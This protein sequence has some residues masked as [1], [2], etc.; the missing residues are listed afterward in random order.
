[1][2]CVA[3]FII[4]IIVGVFVAFI[5]I[6]KPKVGK[7]YLKTLKRSWGCVGKRITL[8][9]CETGLGDDI[10]NSILSKLIIKKP[11]LVKPVSAAIEI[12]SILIVLITVWSLVEGVKAGLAL[13]SLG[14]CN[15]QHAEACSLGSEVCS[16]DGNEAHNPIEAIGLWFS[17]WGEIFGAIPDKF[18]DWNAENFDAEGIKLSSGKENAPKAID[19]FDPGCVVCLQSYKAQKE[20]GFFENYDVTLVPF[21]IQDVN[22][23][24]KYANSKLI[25]QY[26]FAT[27]W[28][29]DE[30]S[31]MFDQ[32]AVRIIDRIF[33]EQDEKYRSYQDLF[34]DYYSAEEAEAKLQEWLKEFGYSDEDIQKIAELAKSDRVADAINKNNDLIVNNM[35]AKGIPTMLYDGKKHTG[36]YEVK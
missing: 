4:L 21:P 25:A 6:F 3:A 10:K 18:R 1:M 22:G 13:Y 20:S 32:P 14:T 33:M 28:Y 15:V 16:I 36:R 30:A 2:V 8:Q 24:F 27:Y 26:I 7:K 34:N 9:K 35:H 23:K 12:A 17:D 29:A 5:S 11:K 19:F 31:T